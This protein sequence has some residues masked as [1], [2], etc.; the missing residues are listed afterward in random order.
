MSRP[1]QQP[2][3]QRLQ[4]PGEPNRQGGQDRRPDNRGQR[5]RDPNIPVIRMAMAA[6]GQY[7]VGKALVVVHPEGDVTVSTVQLPREPGGTAGFAEL[8][9]ERLGEGDKYAVIGIATSP[10]GAWFTPFNIVKLGKKEKGGWKNLEE[11]YQNQPGTRRVIVPANRLMMENGE[12]D[13]AHPGC[14]SSSFP[15]IRA[16]PNMDHLRRLSEFSGLDFSLHNPIRFT[17]Y[18]ALA[19]GDFAA[20]YAEEADAFEAI[21]AALRPCEVEG[22]ESLRAISQ[23]GAGYSAED[24]VVTVHDPARAARADAIAM[25]NRATNLPT[26]E[27]TMK[28]MKTIEERLA[29]P[30]LPVGDEALVRAMA[31]D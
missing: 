16:C 30:T 18:K 7:A 1:Q 10:A 29:P 23:A 3:T 9:A 19:P 22:V 25:E 15:L 28:A 8:R 27:Q 11:D 4:I 12:P 6:S 14:G 31:F 5:Q 17:K 2:L 26:Y 21:C 24:G 13:P 20:A